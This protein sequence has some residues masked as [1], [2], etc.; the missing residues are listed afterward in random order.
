MN[1]DKALISGIFPASLRIHAVL[2]D[3]AVDIVKTNCKR[4]RTVERNAEEISAMNKNCKKRWSKIDDISIFTNMYV[5]FNLND[6]VKD[7]EKA[8]K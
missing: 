5:N 3:V 7:I 1:R 2:G 6:V 4:G 8:N